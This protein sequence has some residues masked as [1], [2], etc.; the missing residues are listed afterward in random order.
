MSLATYFTRSLTARRVSSWRI[1]N[2]K[3]SLCWQTCCATR[4]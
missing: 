1:K 3:L 2:K 4:L